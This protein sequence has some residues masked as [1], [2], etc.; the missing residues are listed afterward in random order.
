MSLSELSMYYGALPVAS[1]LDSRSNKKE[2]KE[3][4]SLFNDVTKTV[5]MRLLQLRL[6]QYSALAETTMDENCISNLNASD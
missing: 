6:T 5:H 3:P 4:G 2:R 1:V